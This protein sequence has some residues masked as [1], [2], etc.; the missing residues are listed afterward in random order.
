MRTFPD[1]IIIAKKKGIFAGES[2]IKLTK[3]NFS[4]EILTIKN[5][6]IY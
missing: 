5:Y 6:N 4:L 1:F 2:S 3:I